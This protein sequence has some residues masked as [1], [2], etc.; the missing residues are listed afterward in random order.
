MTQL[1]APVIFDF[2]SFDFTD[3]TVFYDDGSKYVLHSF[4]Q[5]NTVMIYNM[6]ADQAYW[7]APQNL[8]IGRFA[9]IH[10][11]LYGHGYNTSESYKLFDGGSFNGQDIDAN[12]TFAYNGPGDRTQ[13][14]GSDE[15]YIEGYI[16]QNTVLSGIVKEDLDSCQTSQAF[17]IDGSDNSFVCYGGGG[18]SLGDTA[19]GTQT[20]G[21]SQSISAPLPA[22][23]HVIKPYPQNSYYLEGINFN[24]KGVDLQWELLCWGTNASFTNEGNNFI[25]Q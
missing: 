8:N 20:L 1:S 12:A 17:T 21:G 15:I 23:F 25:T 5:N 22:W 2:D 3:S 13:S 9:V 10:G 16:K 11:E 19:L 24:T 6:N 4:P 7:E 18:N 14:K